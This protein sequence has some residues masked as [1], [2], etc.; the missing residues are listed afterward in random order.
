MQV[1]SLREGN[2]RAFYRVITRR[3]SKVAAVMILVKWAF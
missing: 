1:K 3:K 2:N